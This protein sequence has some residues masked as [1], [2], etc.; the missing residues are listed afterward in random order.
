MMMGMHFM[1][2]VP[3]KKVYIH[4]LVRDG[5]GQKMSKSKGNVID[6]LDL[7]DQFGADAV[8]FTLTA[9]A[10]QGRDVRL[11]EDRV[12]GYRNFATK[13]WN[14]TRY[15]EMNDCLPKA[16][17][18]PA[19]VKNKTNQWIIGQVA[20]C[21]RDIDSALENHRFNEGA[22]ACYQFVWGTFC[23]WYLEF[24]KSLLAGDDQAL[25]EEVKGT[26]GWVLEQILILL[27]PFMPYIT[28]ELYGEVAERADGDWLL[29]HEWPSYDDALLN[30]GASAEIEWVQTVISEIRSVRADM[31]VP[32][33][34]EIELIVEG[35]NDGTKANLKKYEAVLKQMARLTAIKAE[36]NAPKGSIKVIVREATYILPIAELI[37]LDQERDRLKKEISKLEDNI[38]KISQQL[39]NKNFVANAP[40]EVIAEKKGIVEQD[41]DK[42]QKLNKALEQLEAA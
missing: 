16:G 5:K 37:D 12:A 20:Q 24:T 38:K 40:E 17:F 13:L 36:G 18:D 15:C 21:Q 30:E 8:R 10:A 11:T 42:K 19:G 14:A 2:D 4:A 27:N 26:T 39:E 29:T 41:E 25:I 6:P 28:E 1:G 35:A 31:N 22:S 32:A 3:F 33:K 9:M 34:A 23:D 7:I